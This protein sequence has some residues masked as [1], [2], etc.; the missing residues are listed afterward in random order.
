MEMTHIMENIICSELRARD[1][2]VDVG[3][4]YENGKSKSG[5][6]INDA[7]AGRCFIQQVLQTGCPVAALHMK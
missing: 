5:A 3:I 7:G 4:V 1:Y 2:H 6:N